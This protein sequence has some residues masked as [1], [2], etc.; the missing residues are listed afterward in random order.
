MK[1]IYYFFKIEN[2]GLLVVE[3]NILYYKKIDKN[4]HQMGVGNYLPGCG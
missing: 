1:L 3:F 4:S 2:K